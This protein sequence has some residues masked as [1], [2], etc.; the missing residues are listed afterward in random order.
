MVEGTTDSRYLTFSQAQGYEELPRQLALEEMNQEARI[1]LWNLLFDSAWVISDFAIFV[2]GDWRQ[3]LAEVHIR[4]FIRPVDEFTPD[5]MA[6]VEFY[7]TAILYDLTFNKLFDLVQLLL[8][9]PKCPTV[10]IRDVADVFSQCRLAYV[11]DTEEPVT[12]LPATTEHEGQ[13]IIGAINEF[14]S[15]G[16]KGTEAHLRKAGELV[17]QGDWPGIST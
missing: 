1:R 3:I 13:V 14:R 9:H 16:L 7:K 12:I 15:A 6:T 2:R 4:F 5:S 10:F 17:N 11:V 8:R